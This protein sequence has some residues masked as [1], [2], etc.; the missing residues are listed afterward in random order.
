MTDNQ[1]PHDWQLLSRI[2]NS[3]GR[4]DHPLYR[5]LAHADY[6]KE[7]RLLALESAFRAGKIPLHGRRVTAL[8]L[9]APE[10]IE[11]KINADTAIEITL[12]EVTLRNRYD[13][14]A[15]L[16]ASC[17]P[18]ER[19]AKAIESAAPEW[20]P[21]DETLAEIAAMIPRNGPFRSPAVGVIEFAVFQRVEADTAIVEQLLRENYLPAEGLAD[22][23][24]AGDEAPDAAETKFGAWLTGLPER[25]RLTREKARK[26]FNQGKA[27]S[28]IIGG[29]PFL[30]AW[31]KFAHSSW[32]APGRLPGT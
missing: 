32:H 2:C 22:E 4:H 7:Y 29:R 25:P 6:P 27:K 24:L 31:E 18:H 11:T 17:R 20:I 21:S 16:A 10:H 30:R 28:E 5:A 19:P 15:D 8:E 26:N 1:A 12:N 3:L 13:S 9:G 23:P 14:A